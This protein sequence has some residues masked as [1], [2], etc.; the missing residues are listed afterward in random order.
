MVAIPDALNPRIRCPNHMHETGICA[1]C[2]EAIAL[3]DEGVVVWPFAERPTDTEELTYTFL[4]FCS[5]KCL[6]FDLEAWG[7]A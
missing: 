7:T 6:N 3:S 1:C 2:E 5:L 4:G